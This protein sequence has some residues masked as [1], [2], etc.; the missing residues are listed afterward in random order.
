M[1]LRAARGGGGI[2]SIIEDTS[3]A[4]GGFL[5]ANGNFI[6]MQTGGDITSA[7]PLVIDTDGDSFDVTGTTNFSALTVAADRHFFTQ[8]DG[9]L[10]M[11]HGGS[12]VLP[13]A[14]N[15]TTAAG[16]VAEWISTAASTVRCVSYTKADGKAVVKT[17]E[18]FTSF[19][20][21]DDTTPQLGGNLDLVG[22]DL[23]N[24]GAEDFD[25]TDKGS[26]STGTVTFTVT[27][28]TKQKLTVTGGLTLAFTGWAS[29]GAYQE[30]E[31]MLVNGGSNVT[32]ATVNWAVGDGATS[33]TFADTGITLASSGTNHLIVWTTD[34]GSTLY[35]VAS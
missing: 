23:N 31:V 26:V 35:G 20:V 18:S 32:H 6:Q 15:I 5:D 13:G 8:F 30:I 28:D 10:T 1:T 24:I 11:T 34:G 2:A 25:T 22:Y 9:V 27:D 21:V 19:D 14:A 29:S 16:D 17:S 33:T 7:S 3:P 4:L 12:L